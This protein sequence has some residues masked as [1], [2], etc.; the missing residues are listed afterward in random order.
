MQETR[1]DETIANCIKL[2]NYYQYWNCSQKEGARSGNRYSGVSLWSKIEPIRVEYSLPNLENDE[3]RIIFAEF[4]D[5]Y[6]LNTYV[7]NAGTNFDYRTN[8]WDPAILEFLQTMSLSEKKVI[9]CGDL[10]VGITPL[11]VF[12]SDPL[13]SSYDKAALSGVGNSA[14]AGYTKE[15]RDGIIKILDTGYVDVFRTLY[16]FTRDYTW[17]NMRIPAFRPANKGW[18]IDRFI[19]HKDLLKNVHDMKIIRNAG[20]LTKPSGSD[21][22]AIFLEMK[23]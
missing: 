4:D 9:W 17:W 11:D 15:E 2:K 22:A 21:H 19:I 13:S 6:I 14:K 8:V 5:F 16:P 10:N 20:L 7:P 3:G 23:L 1:C 12:W 18:N